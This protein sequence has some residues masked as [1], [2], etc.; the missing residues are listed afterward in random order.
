MTSIQA[1]AATQNTITI[2]PLFKWDS[3]DCRMTYLNLY[4]K[5]VFVLHIEKSRLMISKLSAYI[6]IKIINNNNIFNAFI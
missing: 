2:Q 6:Q 1:T 4:P 5:S 3:E